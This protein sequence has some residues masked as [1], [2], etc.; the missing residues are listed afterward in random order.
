MAQQNINDTYLLMQKII[1]KNQQGY[2][3]P[4]DFNYFINEASKSLFNEYRGKI[5]Q[6]VAGRPVPKAGYAR[7]Q[8][9]S[10][11]L[12]YFF[13]N[14]ALTLTS[15]VAPMPEDH[16]E[17]IDVSSTFNTGRVLIRRVEHDRFY[18]YTNSSIDTP[19]TE[20]PIYMENNQELQFSPIA[21]TGVQ[22]NYLKAPVAANWGYTIG[23]AGR[24]TYAPTGGVNGDSVNLEWDETEIS[25]VI[26]RAISLM[27]I[28]VKDQQMINWAETQ[29]AQGS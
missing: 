1:N 8:L 10:E 9:I 26:M 12:S 6:Y 24:P 19:T 11:T 3:S 5:T 2:L 16:I 25:N 13:M 4:D 14:A 28:S 29:K 21:L 7:T 17:T 27:G 15:G 20:F 23:F 18:N 22:L